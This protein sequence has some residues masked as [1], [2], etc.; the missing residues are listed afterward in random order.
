[1]SKV[2]V[3]TN[4]PY[5]PSRRVPC[6]IGLRRVSFTNPFTTQQQWRRSSIARI[7]SDGDRSAA[8]R[9]LIVGGWTWKRTGR[10]AT[11]AP[12]T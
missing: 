4:H 8:S 2:Q 7:M 3:T 10:L 9:V 1:M 5:Q 6:H 12:L 11:S